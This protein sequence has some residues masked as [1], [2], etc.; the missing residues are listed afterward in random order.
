[1][2]CLGTYIDSFAFVKMPKKKE[3]HAPVEDRHV[4][5]ALSAGV[6]RKRLVSIAWA[7]FDPGRDMFVIFSRSPSPPRHHRKA[8]S[9]WMLR[10]RES[11]ACSFLELGARLLAFAILCW[12]S[13]PSFRTTRKSPNLMRRTTLPRSMRSP[14]RSLV[15]PPS[16]LKSAKSAICTSGFRRLPAALLSNFTSSTCTPWTS[17]GSQ[18]T[19]CADRDPFSPSTRLSMTWTQ[20]RTCV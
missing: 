6:K 16:F 13:A 8:A 15:R 12:M 17:C 14:M 5:D 11:A 20:H 4:E 3:V 9:V 19:V 18:G 10:L 1:M 7:P 2:R